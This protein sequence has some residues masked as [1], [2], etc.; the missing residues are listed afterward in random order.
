MADK[1]AA[2]AS[3]V[4]EA[5]NTAIGPLRTDTAAI[6]ARLAAFEARALVT[7]QDHR[8]TCER[9]AVVEARA[10]IPGPVGAPGAPGAPGVDGLG[11]EDLVATQDPAD[12]RIVTLAYKR[13]EVLREFA[14]LRLSTPRYCGVFEAGRTYA[15]GDQVTWGGSQWHCNA[16]T[17][18]RP[19]AGSKDW[20]L[21]VKCGRDGRDAVAAGVR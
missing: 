17:S 18:T 20:T 11:V 5:I 9:L 7:E 1:T 12:D 8:A 6:V 3:I 10:P 19:G 14:T 15:R 16:D 21:A 2:L 4:A 13:G